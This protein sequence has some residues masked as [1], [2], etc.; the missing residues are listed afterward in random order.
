MA[1]II[2]KLTFQEVEGAAL[3]EQKAAAEDLLHYPAAGMFL[4]TKDPNEVSA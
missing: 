4:V 2:K 3:I 1:K